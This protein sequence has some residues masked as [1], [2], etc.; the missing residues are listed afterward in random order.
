MVALRQFPMFASAEL[1]DVIRDHT[2]LGLVM[3]SQFAGALLDI[4]DRTN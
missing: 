4:D 3:L 1:V 2:E